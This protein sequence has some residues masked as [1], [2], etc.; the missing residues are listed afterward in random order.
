MPAYDS[1]LYQRAETELRLAS[2]SADPDVARIHHELANLY[3]HRFFNPDRVAMAEPQ[4]PPE[5]H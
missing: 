4:A 3:L 2:S 1:Y 5:R